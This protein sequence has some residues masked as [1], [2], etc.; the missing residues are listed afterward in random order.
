MS[1]FADRLIAWQ[2]RH[3]R[4]DLPWQGTRDPYRVWLSEI[5]LQQTQVDSVKP[6]YLRFLARFP[7]VASLAAAP[8]ED[9]LA[10]WSGLGYYA[11]AR[12]LHRAA[13]V[14]MDDFGGRFPQD[15]AQL[16]RLP[17]VGRSTAAAIASF[18]FGER[19]AILD[20]NVKRVLCRHFGIEGFPGERKVE[21]ALWA[22]ATRLLPVAGVEVYPQAQMD[23]GATVCT[24]GKPACV[25]CPVQDGCV[26]WRDG[27][28]AELPA[29]RPRKAVPQRQCDMLVLCSPRAVLLEQ[30]PARGV[31]GGLYSLPELVDGETPQAGA[32]RLLGTPL[33]DWRALPPVQHAFTHFRLEIRP[34]L[35]RL[36]AS[37][38][39]AAEGRLDWIARDALESTGLPA[40]VR[41]LLQAALAD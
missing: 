26:A 22:L 1:E 14:V 3:G 25:R 15:A 5:M 36:E 30:R 8:V 32:L 37:A 33:Q 19:V 38:P 34:W 41:K 27:R 10:L 12:N 29:P 11:R 31:W 4:H 17:G 28:Q 21:E 16:Q 6:Y 13:Q 2:R 39:I 35:R 7:D 24:R 9:V 20:G 23:L 40:P 18:C